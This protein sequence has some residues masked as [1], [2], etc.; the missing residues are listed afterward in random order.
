MTTSGLFTVNKQLEKHPI[1]ESL[2]DIEELRIFMQLHVFAVW[3]F[4]SLLKELQGRLAP[5][6]A[7]WFPRQNS[8]VVRL[9]NE[10]VLEEESDIA[11]PN[12]C[13]EYASHYEIYLMAMDEI[14]ASTVQIKKFL[15]EVERLGI[16][17]ALKNGSAPVPVRKF[18]QSTFE[19]IEKGKVH[20]IAASFA[21]GRE[22]L[23]P[24]MFSRILESCGVDRKQAPLFHYYLE[25]HAHLDGEQ[26]GP[27]AEHL[28]L[29]LINEDSDKREEAVRSAQKSVQARV[30]LWDAVLEVMPNVTTPA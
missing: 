11:H 6:G 26:H 16:N 13:N 10:I 7:P 21:Y 28:V 14:G 27:M 23:V 24:L 30:A 3:D 17:L 2:N 20:E 4:M 12:G 15:S 5:H 18:L 9:V 29:S 22:N 25:R 19:T 1:F 8:H